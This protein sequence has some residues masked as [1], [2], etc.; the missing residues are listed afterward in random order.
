MTNHLE[1]RLSWLVAIIA[2]SYVA[3]T[4]YIL[5]HRGP[6]FRALFAG[7]GAELPLATRWVLAICEPRFT[8]PL[9][10]GA[11]AFLVIKEIKV[12]NVVSRVLISV[13][14]FMATACIAAVT[15]EAFFQPM[16]RLIEQIR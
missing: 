9:S 8:W 10:L 6:V 11:I 16:F 1:Q 7:L 5:G 13:V 2:S 15:T 3:W 14:V 4:G 12:Q